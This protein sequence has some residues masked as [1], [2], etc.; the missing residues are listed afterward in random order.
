LYIEGSSIAL[1]NFGIKFSTSSYLFEDIAWLSYS[2]SNEEKMD[3]R[4]N[5]KTGSVG[6]N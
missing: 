5:H 1:I 4:M 6:I 2:V 3:L